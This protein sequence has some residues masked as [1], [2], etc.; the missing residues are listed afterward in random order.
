MVAHRS[1]NNRVE[2]LYDNGALNI[3]YI[4]GNGESRNQCLLC[5]S[6][7]IIVLVPL[8]HT[9]LFNLAKNNL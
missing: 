1:Q 8:G 6:S 9:D 7:G 4:W 3:Q 5:D 2:R